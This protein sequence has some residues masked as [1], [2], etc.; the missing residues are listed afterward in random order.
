MGP[1]RLG[2]TSPT[3]SPKART[4]ANGRVLEVGEQCTDL[5]PTG[6]WENTPPQCVRGCDGQGGLYRLL[7]TV[8]EVGPVS[9]GGETGLEAATVA[10]KAWGVFHVD[11]R[12][13]GVRAAKPGRNG[14]ALHAHRRSLRKIEYSAQQQPTV[15][16]VGWHL[17]RSHDHRGGN[18]PLGT[19]QRDPGVQRS[20]LSL[21][22]G[23]QEASD[24]KPRSIPLIQP[25]FH[26]GILTVAEHQGNPGWTNSF[27][28]QGKRGCCR[29][30]PVNY[31]PNLKIGSTKCKM[32]DTNFR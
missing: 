8:C 9:P 23:K 22:G 30:F 28:L 27:N 13:P 5:W 18:R 31:C 3:H 17:Q 24:S 21:G 4:A 32:P 16:Q 25:T 11:H 20:Q 26:C 7:C 2:T 12:R 6:L 19:P 1:N 29:R 10:V 14:G 15:L